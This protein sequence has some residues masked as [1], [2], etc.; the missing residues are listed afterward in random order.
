MIHSIITSSIIERGHRSP[1]LGAVYE[2]VLSW[3]ILLPTTVALFAPNYGKFN[4]TSKGGTVKE[5]YVDWNIIKPY[6]ILIALNAAGFIFGSWQLLRTPHPEYL[7]LAIN[8]AWILYNLMILGVTVSVA[9]E[10]VQERKFPRVRV[11]TPAVLKRAD[12]T[13]Y[14]AELTD[15]SQ[16]GVSLK[17][18]DEAVDQFFTG[19]AVELI[20][21]NA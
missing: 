10:T 15:Y 4:V 5:N 8:G 3:Y 9:V 19:N 7:T 11:N 20:L 16:K 13:L 14:D 12:G 17:L 6:C 1:F 2:A 18:H 21:E